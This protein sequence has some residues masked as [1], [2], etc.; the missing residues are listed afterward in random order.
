MRRQLL[1]RCTVAFPEVG[2]N[3]GVAHD[4]VGVAYMFYSTVRTLLH[5]SLYDLFVVVL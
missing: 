4:Y 5:F 1:C 3:A 2:F